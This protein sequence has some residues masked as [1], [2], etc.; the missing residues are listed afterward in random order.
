MLEKNNYHDVQLFAIL[1]FSKLI[2][3]E[4]DLTLVSSDMEKIFERC[5][6]IVLTNVGQ[7]SL[8]TDICFETLAYLSLKSSFKSILVKH[9]EQLC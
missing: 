8:K 4:E 5:M 7:H 3:T 2:S 9:I 6:Q 1:L